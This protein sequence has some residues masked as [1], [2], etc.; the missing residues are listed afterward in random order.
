MKRFTELTIGRSAGGKD[1]WVE[2]A[3]RRGRAPHAMGQHG[4]RV[5]KGG[6]VGGNQ[7][8]VLESFPFLRLG[9]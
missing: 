2:M 7:V 8:F 3:R 6:S 5:G 9:I 4:L 1:L